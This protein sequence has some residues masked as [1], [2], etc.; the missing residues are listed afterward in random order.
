MGPIY[1]FVILESQVL[2]IQA[3]SGL[4]ASF[5]GGVCLPIKAR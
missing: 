4:D 5:N 3:H 1:I 2:L